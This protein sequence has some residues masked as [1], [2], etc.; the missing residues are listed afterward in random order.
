MAKEHEETPTA[1]VLVGMLRTLWNGQHDRHDN[2][3]P[4]VPG[5][6][7]ITEATVAVGLAVTLV[8][9]FS[10]GVPATPG[11]APLRHEGGGSAEPN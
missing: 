3:E 2:G 7:S 5:S 11:K 6:V 9:W 4:S 1:E 10:A 8:H